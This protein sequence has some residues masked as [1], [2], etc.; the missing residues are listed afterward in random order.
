MR[1]TEIYHESNDS[2]VT[3][4]GVLYSL[5]KLFKSTDK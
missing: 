1:L 2:T 3:H 4:D 5:N